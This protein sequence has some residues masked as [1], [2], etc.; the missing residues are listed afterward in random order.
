MTETP[1][2]P[3][4]DTHFHLAPDDDLAGIAARAEAAGVGAMLLAG[5]EVGLMGAALARIAPYPRIYA[6]VGVHP[7]AA[8]KWDG[9]MAPYRSWAAQEQVRAIGEIGLDY[10]YDYGPRE[11]QRRCFRAFLELAAQTG[12][13]AVIHCRDAEDRDGAYQDVYAD[14]QAVLA[15]RA[16][17][18]VHCFTG[19][20]AWAG[21]FLALGGH[22]SFTGLVSFK[23]AENVREA[24]RVVPLDRLMFETD[25]PYLAPVPY[26]GKPNEPAY[27]RHVVLSAAQTLGLDAA[28]L[29][30]RSTAVAER[31]FALP[32]VTAPDA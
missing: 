22:L 18:V 20:V 26:R 21:K 8:G 16:G 12:K 1:L 5:A 6:A 7:H 15:G 28:E 4:V 3:L 27:L 2:P 30:A 14:L 29:A 23:K 31:F 25:S 10:F 13:P 32:P 17:F 9:D 11:A 24:M 19:T